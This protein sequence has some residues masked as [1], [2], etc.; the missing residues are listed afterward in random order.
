MSTPAGS[1]AGDGASVAASGPIGAITMR[2]NLQRT[3]TIPNEAYTVPQVSTTP[4]G[5]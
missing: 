3:A 5:F 1:E 4:G 2:P